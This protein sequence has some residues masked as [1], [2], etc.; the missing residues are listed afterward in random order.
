MLTWAPD[1]SDTVKYKSSNN[2]DADDDPFQI[3]N[4]EKNKIEETEKAYVKMKTIHESMSRGVQFKKRFT[5]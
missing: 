5:G 2:Q 3:Y 4:Q 1:L